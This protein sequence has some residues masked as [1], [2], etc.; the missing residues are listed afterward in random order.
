MRFPKK[1]SEELSSSFRS[2]PIF[3]TATQNPTFGFQSRHNSG[4]NG[5]AYLGKADTPRVHQL[6][7]YRGKFLCSSGAKSA[8]KGHK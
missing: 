5:I 7:S 3:G 4:T 1:L 2:V 8:K 6:T